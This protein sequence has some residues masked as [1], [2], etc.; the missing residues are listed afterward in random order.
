MVPLF[1][2]PKLSRTMPSL[3]PSVIPKPNGNTDLARMVMAARKARARNGRTAIQNRT[4]PLPRHE[5]RRVES[6]N[7]KTQILTANQSA[8]D[9]NPRLATT[10]ATKTMR[11]IGRRSERNVLSQCRKNRKAESNLRT[12]PPPPR[13]TLVPNPINP[14]GVGG[15]G[16]HPQ[17]Q[18]RS[19]KP[20]NPLDD[21]H[22]L[23]HSRNTTTRARGLVMYT[24]RYDRNVRSRGGPRHRAPPVRVSSS[25]TTK[26]PS[27]RRIV[28]ILESG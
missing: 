19:R 5:K 8:S 10:T 28:C 18:D 23:H 6:Q 11:K 13:P 16:V 22:P 12:S 26:G 7:T 14:P 17:S 24:G 9:K 20:R 25:A 1:G 27:T 15:L 3:N 21:R 2:V 4:T